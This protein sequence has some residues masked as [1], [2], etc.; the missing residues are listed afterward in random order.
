VKEKNIWIPVFDPDA[1]MI[2][3]L[4]TIWNFSKATGLF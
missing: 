2:I 4:V 3:S 1:I